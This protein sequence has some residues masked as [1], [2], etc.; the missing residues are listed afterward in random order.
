[1]DKVPATIIQ[2]ALALDSTAC[3][4]EVPSVAR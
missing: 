4:N 3:T 2:I 1:M